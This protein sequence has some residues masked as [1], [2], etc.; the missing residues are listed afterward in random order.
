MMKR[1]DLKT[2]M[3]N[4]MMKSLFYV[5]LLAMLAAGGW[6]YQ[7]LQGPQ[8]VAVTQAVKGPATQAVYATGTVE[9]TV[10]VPIAPRIT[11][12]LIKLD[13]D[14]GS[15]VKKGEV[16]AQLEDQDLQEAIKE[17]QAKEAYAKQEYDRDAE[18]VKKNA[19]SKS[20]FERSKSDW[21]AAKAAVAKATVEQ[22]FSTLTAP[23]DGTIIRRDGEVGQLIPANQP[24]FWMSCCSPLRISAEVDEEDIALVQPGQEVLIRA[25][26]FPGQVFHGKV[27]SITPKG[28]PISRSYRVR[29]GF[30]DMTPLLIGMTVENNI[31]TRQTDDALLI[32]S[33]AIVQG[34][35]WLV[36][37]GKLKKQKV[38]VGAKGSQQTE[39][40]NGIT[41]KD[42]VVVAPQPG[43]KEGQAVSAKLQVQGK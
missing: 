36:E 23:D 33:G 13:A 22:S 16:L 38:T 42:R 29:I 1:E 31:I 35:V 4:R 15:R 34:Y 43:F 2:T 28:D 21:D 11:A 8:K 17:L 30:V 6:F 18:L 10:M 25:D 40:I 12:Q 41:E 5:I 9:A 27:Q 3:G 14:E 37:G 39:I 7:H 26:A 19:V 32:P 24:V 20:E